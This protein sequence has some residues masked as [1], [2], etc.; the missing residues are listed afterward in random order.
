MTAVYQVFNIIFFF[1]LGKTNNSQEID[2]QQNSWVNV[3]FF[4]LLQKQ[5][6]FVNDPFLSAMTSRC[7]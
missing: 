3:N 4:I 7:N 6:I 5:E 1:C 2:Y